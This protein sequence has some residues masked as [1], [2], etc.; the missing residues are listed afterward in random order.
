MTL[1]KGF[2]MDILCLMGLYPDEY[3]EEIESQSIK[4]MQYAADK[5]QKAIIKGLASID[6][7]EVSIVN[8]LYIGSYPKKYRSLRI[9][10]FEFSCQGRIKGV[11]VGFVNLTVLKWFS[12]YFNTKKA[13][14]QWA[15]VKTDQEKIL[16]IYAMT[17]PFMQI[18][19]YI[20]KKYKNVKICVVVPD[21]PDYMNTAAMGERSFYRL[22]KNAEISMIRSSIRHVDSYV[23]LV[24]TMK[25]WFGYPVRY[26]VVEGIASG[27]IESVQNA[28]KKK[29]ILYAGGIKHEYGV[30]DLIESFIKADA[31]QWELLIYGDGA[32]LEAIRKMASDYPNIKIMGA[33]AN[34]EV[35]AE[36]RKA[37]ILVNPRKNQVFTR[38]SFP[39]KI[40]E[41]MASGTPMLAYKLEGVPDEY[42]KYYYHIDESQ[43]GFVDAL[44]SVMQLTEEER[45]QKGKEAQEFVIKCKNPKVQCKKIVELLKN[46]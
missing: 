12:R 45:Q 44:K 25:E 30:A 19:S 21:L 7:V 4:G 29:S 6:G 39:S 16:L 40:L 32:D 24:D 10:S 23:L 43:D 28:P 26:T 20:G 2:G 22:A 27:S 17:T 33:R 46:S 18:A 9:P 15:K 13:V 38:Y 31:A 8:S 42:D 36:Q 35:V 14:E 41:Y 5:L 37:S 1:Q 11:N 3:R 34:E